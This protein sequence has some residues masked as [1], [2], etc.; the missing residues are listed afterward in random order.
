[1][2]KLTLILVTTLLVSSCY[3]PTQMKKSLDNSLNKNT[4]YLRYQF[5]PPKY[6]LPNGNLGTIWVYTDTYVQSLPGYIGKYGYTY[7]YQP[8]SSYEYEASNRFWVNNDGIII[9]WHS[10]GYQLQRETAAAPAGAILVLGI[11]VLMVV[12]MFSTFH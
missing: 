5:G 10:Q 9:K 8:P 7:L 6:I 2:K 1:M 3:V 12:T 11:V 4:D